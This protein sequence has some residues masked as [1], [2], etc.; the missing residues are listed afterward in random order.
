M[1]C[2]VRA[3]GGG[4]HLIELCLEDA[5]VLAELA[6]LLPVAVDVA[7]VAREVGQGALVDLV[8]S[9]LYV[10]AARVRAAARLMERRAATSMIGVCK[11]EGVAVSEGAVA[12]RCGADE[13]TCLSGEEQM[14]LGVR[15]GRSPDTSLGLHECIRG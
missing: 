2:A 6:N 4:G 10:D 3:L 9:V 13:H 11:R 15:F 5:E 8:F 7:Q 12:R 14:N 1:P